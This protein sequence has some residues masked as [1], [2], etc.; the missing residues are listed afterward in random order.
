[1]G[2]KPLLFIPAVLALALGCAF[3]GSAAATFPGSTGKMAWDNSVG[4]PFDPDSAPR[5]VFSNGAL[6]ATPR[7]SPDGTQIAYATDL[8]GIWIVNADGSGARQLTSPQ[9]DESATE[10]DYSPAWS[11]DGKQ[12]VFAR[13]HLEVCGADC[14]I[15]KSSLR[16]TSADS[17]GNGS[18]I[19]EHTDPAVDYFYKSIDWQPGGERIVADVDHADIHELTSFTPT[20]GKFVIHRYQNRLNL[21]PDGRRVSWAPD[22][23]RLA[24]VEQH[25]NAIQ[26]FDGSTLD[27]I[28]Q[29]ALSDGKRIG[30]M[31]FTP[32]GSHLLVGACAPVGTFGTCTQRLLL[33]PPPDADVDPQ[34]PREIPLPGPGPTNDASFSVDFQPADLPVIVIPGF[35]GTEMLCGSTKLWPSLRETGALLNLRLNASGTGNAPG[36]CGARIGK[37]IGSYAF[38][39]FYDPLHDQIDKLLTDP[40]DPRTKNRVYMFPW[41]WRLDPRPQ[42]SRLNGAIT[43]ALSDE[44]SKAQG[45]DE[46]V[47]VAHSMGGLLVRA[48]LN[49]AAITKRIRRVLTIGTP[50][51]G[52]PKALFPLLA[53]VDSP[54]GG[55]LSAALIPAELQTMSKTHT[56]NFILY[57]SSQYGAWLSAATRKLDD[58]SGVV[59]YVAHLGGSRRAWAL[60]QQ[61]K[62]A[63]SGF[64]RLRPPGLRE[65]R[66]LAGGAIATISGIDVLAGGRQAGLTFATGD[67]TVPAFSATQTPPGSPKPLGDDVRV[68][69]VCGIDHLGLVQRPKVF[70]LIG[71]F[72]RYGSPPRKTT[73]CDF[74]GFEYTIVD[75]GGTTANAAAAANRTLTPVGS[76]GLAALEKAETAGL[77]D[78][79]PLRDETNIVM[80][81]SQP[82]LAGIP[83]RHVLVTATPISGRRAGKPLTYGPI[84]GRLTLGVSANGKAVLKLGGR[85]L[86]P[87]RGVVPRIAIEQP[88]LNA[89][90]ALVVAIVNRSTGAVRVA[91]AIGTPGR[92]AVL[93]G[94]ARISAG[95]AATVTIRGARAKLRG[96]RSVTITASVGGKVIARVSAPLQPGA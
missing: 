56:G 32:D 72:I 41:D 15:H 66:V 43:T 80:S 53:G 38:V 90:G 88:R 46:V 5:P 95:R 74:S 9:V 63:T 54:G 50:Y 77:L 57:P 28:G 58:I 18:I 59:N 68:S 55:A 87:R 67:G 10:Y 11:A 27:Q 17:G 83:V 36:T 49:D 79:I 92:A 29:L 35:L 47:L 48:A 42:L 73:P 37:V 4:D 81:R 3:P 1:M 65:F 21:E 34:E 6:L 85:T 64:K 69:Y 2:R 86:T 82:G 93:R 25:G 78:V 96:A 12:V 76:S 26:M 19:D 94:A 39:D 70:D 30:G 61:F 40:N 71:D 62:A 16:L 51:L 31:T 20:G 52:T 33:A 60:A 22:G 84:S 23:K 14:E 13:L 7:W 91:L 75:I 45:L 8:A 44:L 89:R 24:F